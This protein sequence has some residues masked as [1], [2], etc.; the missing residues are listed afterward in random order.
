MFHH[1]LSWECAVGRG[2]VIVGIACW[3]LMMV[4]DNPWQYYNTWVCGVSLRQKI[5]NPLAHIVTNHRNYAHITPQAVCQL[6]LHNI[7]S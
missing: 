7:N 4:S 2:K 1:S 6:P 3:Y 5:P